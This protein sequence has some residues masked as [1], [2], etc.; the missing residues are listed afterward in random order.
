[1]KNGGVI[2]EYLIKLANNRAKERD[3]DI[4]GVKSAAN[5][6]IWIFSCPIIRTMWDFD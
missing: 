4:G 5:T 2:D 6:T 1:M 3:I